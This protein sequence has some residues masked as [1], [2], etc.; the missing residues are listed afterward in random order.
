[1]LGCLLVLAGMAVGQDVVLFKN[2]YPAPTFQLHTFDGKVVDVPSLRGKVVLLNFWATWCG[3]CRAEI[4][5]LIELQSKYP[6]RLK[7]VGLSIDETSPT[8]V[9]QFAARMGINYPVGMAGP[10]LQRAF[11]GIAAVPTTVVLDTLGQVVQRNRGQAPLSVFENE[12]RA[13]LALPV[14]GKV[15]RY[16]QL[17]PNGRVGTTQIPGLIDEFK[18]LTPAQ[19]QT[20]LARLNSQACTCGCE[21]SLA[22][23]RVE[24]PACGYSL[25]QAKAVLTEIR[26]AH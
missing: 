19:R 24:D 3:P 12:V 17:S 10:E 6:G 9:K 23:C 7:V 14:E 18:Q 25:P 13:L 2:P 20:A 22:S 8:F 11:G 4:P 1:M 16:D 26:A 15:V 5:E 21:R